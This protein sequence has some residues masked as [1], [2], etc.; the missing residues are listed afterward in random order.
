MFVGHRFVHEF[1]G[2]PVGAVILQNIR[3]LIPQVYQVLLRFLRGKQ[4]VGS[5]ATFVHGI[6]IVRTDDVQVNNGTQLVFASPL[7]G[8]GQQRPGLRQFVSLLVPE[9]HFVNGNTHK[10]E[11]KVMESLKVLLLNVQT[12]HLASCLRLRQP[13]THIGATL[14]V[15][16]VDFPRLSHRGDT[17]E[18]CNSQ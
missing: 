18:C 17:H 15:E 3:Q 9:L 5:S 7:Q 11:T 16:V 8:I 13:V 12:A 1:I 6:E 14:D 2:N 4:G 10:V